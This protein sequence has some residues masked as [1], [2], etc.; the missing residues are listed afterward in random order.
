M[1]SLRIEKDLESRLE[2]FV[3]TT[4]LSRSAVVKKAL[5]EMLDRVSTTKN[6]YELGVDLF[7]IAGSG[8]KNLSHDYKRI[9]R[10]KLHAKH[11]H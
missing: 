9:I 5:V 2:A 11:T 8:K 10:K 1:L 6:A 3:R 4:K 7:E